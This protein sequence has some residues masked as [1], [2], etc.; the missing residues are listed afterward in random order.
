MDVDVDGVGAAAAAAAVPCVCT[1]WRGGALGRVAMDDQH[2]AQPPPPG[3]ATLH[4]LPDLGLCLP[5]PLLLPPLHHPE[6][7]YPYRPSRA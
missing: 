7:E 1:G 5:P 3:H 6:E 2:L 4:H